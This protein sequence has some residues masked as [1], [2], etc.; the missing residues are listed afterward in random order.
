[1]DPRFQVRVEGVQF[2]AAHC[3]TIGPECEPLHG[4]SYEVAAQL[5]G[6]LEANSWVVDFVEMKMI[7]RE[8]CD[9]L[10]HRFLLQRDSRVLDIEPQEGAW[11]VR[12]RAGN[13]Y[14]LPATDVVALPVDNTTAERLAQWLCARLWRALVERESDNVER[15]T[16]EVWEGPGQRASYSE[17]RS[18]RMGLPQA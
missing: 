14:V 9:E 2:A 10:D 8:I 17:E 16:V 12:T 11:Q 18:G 13:V 7:L 5:D 3:A 1:M 4:H 15:V 6:Q